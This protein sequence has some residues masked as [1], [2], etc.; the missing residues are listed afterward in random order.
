MLAVTEGAMEG[1][2]LEVSLRDLIENQTHPQTS[3][4]KDIVVPTTE[5][6]IRWAGHVAHVADSWCHYTSS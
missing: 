5:S 2:M 3:G 6:K 4:V 1:R